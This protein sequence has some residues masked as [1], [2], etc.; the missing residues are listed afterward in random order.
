MDESIHLTGGCQLDGFRHVIGTLWNVIDEACV[1]MAQI[2]YE[3]MSAGGMTDESVCRGLH[4]ASRAPRDRWLKI[5]V[6]TRGRG[7]PA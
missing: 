3:G 2:V 6:K 4:D 1:N 7:G 5:P